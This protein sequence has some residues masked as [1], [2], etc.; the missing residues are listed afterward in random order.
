MW[1]RRRGG[2]SAVT[3]T[4]AVKQDRHITTSGL[5]HSVRRCSGRSR[6]KPT[7]RHSPAKNARLYASFVAPVKSR[8][9]R[10][11]VS[12]S[13]LSTFPVPSRRSDRHRCS[14][15]GARKRCR[16][17]GGSVHAVPPSSVT[18]AS[19]FTNFT[20]ASHQRTVTVRRP[21]HHGG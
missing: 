14:R 4:I 9:S 19:T 15:R 7:M 21:E 17:S 11:A 2:I 10:S 5:V 16:I 20:S 18:T 6:R 12:H 13:W 3:T 1:S 8:P